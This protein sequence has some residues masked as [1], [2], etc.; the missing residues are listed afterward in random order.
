MNWQSILVVIGIITIV[1]GI[2]KH[3][4]NIVKYAII[5]VIIMQLGFLLGQTAF[6]D[7]IPIR[8]IFK[9]DVFT[10]LGN[11]FPNTFIQDIL[12]AVGQFLSK[13]VLFILNLLERLFGGEIKSWDTLIQ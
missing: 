9:Y 1:G 13:I 3:M 2:I 4:F 10:A 5:G 11:L 7:F 6:N 12:S 8:D